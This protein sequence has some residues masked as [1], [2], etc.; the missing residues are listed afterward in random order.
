LAA[1]L[2]F[3]Y[4]VEKEKKRFL[5]YWAAT[6]YLAFLCRIEVGLLLWAG[7]FTLSRVVFFRRNWKTARFLFLPVA[8]A[9]LTYTIFLQT[10]HGWRGFYESNIKFMQTMLLNNAYHAFHSGT[11]AWQAGLA[12]AVK[13]FF[14]YLALMTALGVAAVLWGK[15]DKGKIASVLFVFG[16]FFLGTK[17]L[18]NIMLYFGWPL[19]LLLG[20][21]L[22][23]TRLKKDITSQAVACRVI[24]FTVALL[25]TARTF[26][27]ATPLGLNFCFGATAIIAF[28]VFFLET[29]KDFLQV[30]I[31]GFS[32][33]I[34]IGL[35]A[36]LFLWLN[37]FALVEIYKNYQAR[38]IQVNTPQGTLF[39]LPSRTTEKFWQTVAYL[40]R[41]S[42][43]AAGVAIFPDGEGINFFSS[44]INPLPYSSFTPPLFDLLGE[45]KIIGDLARILPEYI[46]IVSRQTPEYGKSRFGW[47]Y[48]QKTDAWIKRN[49][50]LEK[51]FG[52]YPFTASDFGIALWRSIKKHEE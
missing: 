34:F 48:G 40:E 30:N 21:G 5:F 36:V 31:G 15:G 47:D 4:A 9:I 25:M 8:A 49:Y 6:M 2:F 27:S 19:I 17:Y 45:D 14:L 52:A 11:I 13:E 28:Y 32:P 1:L 43:V 33:K 46:A 16:A 42:S 39:C 7:F 24:L 50:K 23:A 3:L 41:N 10:V 51:V 35:A 22:A 20:L 18:R 44:R 12:A 29:V 37:S 26:L 38:N